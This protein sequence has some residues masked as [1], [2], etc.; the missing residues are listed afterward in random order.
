ML[1]VGRTLMGTTSVLFRFGSFRIRRTVRKPSM[2]HSCSYSILRTVEEVRRWRNNLAEPTSI[3]FVPTMGALHEGHLQLVRHSLSSQ[4]NT[5]VSIFLNPAQFSPT[6]DLASYPSTLDSDLK[7]L[8]ALAVTP[9]SHPIPHHGF[10]GRTAS[11]S[12]AQKP[13]DLPTSMDEPLRKVSA[14]FLPTNEVLYP[15]GIAPNVEDQ[16]GAFVTVHG[17]S[18]QLEGAR[19]PGFF[20]GVATV[21]LKLFLIVE[22]SIGFFGQKDLQQ[23][24]LVRQLCKDL[25]VIRPKAIVAA[26]T[27]RDTATGLALSSRNAYL[28]PAE[29][30]AAKALF[31]FLHQCGQRVLSAGHT[32]SFQ[33]LAD[34]FT[35]PLQSFSLDFVSINHP[36]SFHEIPPGSEI[37][38]HSPIAISGAML[39]NCGT[40]RI[41][42]LIDNI[43]LNHDLNYGI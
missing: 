12:P 2:S 24:L 37:S 8:A 22:P 17:L 40:G 36:L 16:R 29:A 25:H 38:P 21:V 32:P 6:E 4:K 1:E 14:V 9:G 27:V 15:S 13:A 20:R 28:S 11:S 33:E 39:V 5:I 30:Q 23:C 42:R 18:E 35:P 34:S 43:V 7:Q 31:A 26:P 41:V 3:G 19:R 10:D